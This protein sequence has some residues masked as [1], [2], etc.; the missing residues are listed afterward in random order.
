MAKRHSL[1][2]APA[3][4]V[5]GYLA[6]TSAP[7]RAGFVGLE[8]RPTLCMHNC[9]GAL[10]TFGPEVGFGFVGLGLRFGFADQVAYFIPELR[11]YFDARVSR[12]VY[13]TPFFEFG[14]LIGVGGGESNVQL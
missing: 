11:F 14:P 1:G 10:F 2:I 12:R 8:L 3:L 5:A 7:A 6:M 9:Q 4:L 13:V